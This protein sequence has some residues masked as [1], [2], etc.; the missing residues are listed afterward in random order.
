MTAKSVINLIRKF[1]R[2]YGI[3][4]TWKAP[5]QAANSRGVPVLGQAG[6][7]KQA[8]VLFIKE[9]YNPM[10]DVVMAIGLQHD[11]SRYL[12]TLPDIAIQK[13][14]TITDNHNQKWKLGPVDW[15]DV[16]GIP[17]CKQVALVEIGGIG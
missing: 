12:L 8:K 17:V 3:I 14:L 1:I 4:I 5:A 15:L 7:D 10:K 2:E 6:E 16:G 9:K 13:D 11:H